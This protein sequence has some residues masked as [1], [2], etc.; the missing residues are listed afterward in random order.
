[1]GFIT[2]CGKAAECEKRSVITTCLETWHRIRWWRTPVLTL[3]LSLSTWLNHHV[4]SSI[5]LF[6]P[7]IYVRWQVWDY[8][9]RW[10]C[11]FVERSAIWRVH[12]DKKCRDQG[13]FLD[14]PDLPTALF[15]LSVLNTVAGRH[16][17]SKLHLFVW[18]ACL[19]HRTAWITGPLDPGLSEGVNGLNTW[20]GGCQEGELWWLDTVVFPLFLI[21]AFEKEHRTNVSGLCP[22][23]YFQFN[24]SF[25]FFSKFGP[26]YNVEWG[27][28]GVLQSQ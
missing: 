20:R 16:K 4:C 12:R 18:I 5:W 19:F 6:W 10:V 13:P 26:K 1:M 7:H 2:L 28:V 24:Q 14:F 23:L 9:I 11:V 27:C 22:Q 21:L 17:S 3:F 8:A 25:G 15:I